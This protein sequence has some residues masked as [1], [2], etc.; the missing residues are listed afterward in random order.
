MKCSY[1]CM[2]NYLKFEVGRVK[3]VHSHV[4]I[5]TSTA[6]AVGERDK[7]ASVCH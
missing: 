5:L 2:H 4:A 6:V 7:T 3:R 1:S